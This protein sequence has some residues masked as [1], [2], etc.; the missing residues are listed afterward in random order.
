M[1]KNLEGKTLKVMWTV[2][3]NTNNL[4]SIYLDGQLYMSHL[5]FDEFYPIYRGLLR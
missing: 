1:L 3:E 2:T 4:Y 5:S